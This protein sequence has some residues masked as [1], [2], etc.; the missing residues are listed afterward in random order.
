MSEISLMPE[1]QYQRLQQR[2]AADVRELWD[3]LDAV[4]DPEVPALSIWDLGILRDIQRHNEQVVVTITPTYSGCP[5]M[6]NISTDVVSLLNANGYS[7][8]TVKLA[9]SPA[10]SSEWMSA[11]GRKKLREY[12]IAPPEDA[13]LDDDG[14]TPDAHAAC[15]HCS[16][17]NTR[18][19]SE[20]GSTACKALFQCDDCGEPFDYFKKI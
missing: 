2:S 16:S 20:F 18:R 8:V 9:L 1:E 12:G 14:L 11:E 15:P 19:V 10:W 7:D 17:R 13:E 6:D 5:A 4:K 3:L